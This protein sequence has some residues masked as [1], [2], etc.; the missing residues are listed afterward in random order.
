[1]TASTRVEGFLVGLA[2]AGGYLAA[3]TSLFAAIHSAA[4]VSAE[5]YLTSCGRTVVDRLASC[6]FVPP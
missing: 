3:Q 1:M 2:H 4:P 6:G 5:A